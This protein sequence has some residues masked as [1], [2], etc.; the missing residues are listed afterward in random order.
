M[1]A[2]RP[3][4]SSK[5]RLSCRVRPD[6]CL[7]HVERTSRRRAVRGGQCRRLPPSPPMS[8]GAA[9][10]AFDR[11]ISGPAT[12]KLHSRCSPAAALTPAWNIV[13]SAGVKFRG[14]SRRTSRVIKGRRAASALGARPRA[15]IAAVTGQPDYVPT[16]LHVRRPTNRQAREESA[17]EG[18]A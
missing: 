4:L 8:Q 7:A 16:H 1:D 9:R 2:V 5:P 11:P 6:P 13:S 17:Q 15:V 3:L 10:C 18:S 12:A 14:N